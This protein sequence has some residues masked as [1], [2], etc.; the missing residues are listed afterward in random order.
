M[1]LL[2]IF[3][4]WRLAQGESYKVTTEDVRS[5]LESHVYSNPTTVEVN[6]ATVSALWSFQIGSAKAKSLSLTYATCRT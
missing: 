5:F 3:E 1:D 6:G 2:A 4:A